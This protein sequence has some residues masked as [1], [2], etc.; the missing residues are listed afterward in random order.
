MSPFRHRPS[1]TAARRGWTVGVTLVAA[2]LS[3]PVVVVAAHVFV[4]AGDVW[5]HLV[6][7]V[8]D[9]YILNSLML[10]AGVTLGTLT[11][12][13]TTAWLASMC[14]FPGRSI[15]EW[16]SLLPMAL[17]AYIIAYTYTGLFDFAGPVQGALRSVA[18]WGYGDY[19]FPEIRSIWGA[20]AMLSLVLYPYVYLLTRAAF[21]SQS[22]CV[23]DAS[24]TLG[25]GPWRTFFTVALPL[26]RPATVAGLSLAL[27]ETLADYGTVQYF[28]V[29]TFTT[30][31]FRTWYGLDNAAAASQLAA[32]LLLFVVALIFLER[33]SRRHQRFH[34]TSQR[35]QDLDRIELKGARGII[36]FLLCLAPVLAGFVI[37]AAQLLVWTVEVWS[38]AVDAHFLTLVYNS[39]ELAVLASVLALFLA[40]LLGYGQRLNKSPWVNGAV[41]LAGM[42][43]AIPGTVIAI[44]VVIPLAWVDNTLDSFLRDTFNI[45]SGLLFSGTVFAL[46]FA[47]MVR[48]LAVS[49]QTVS[50]GLGRIKPSIDEAGRSLGHTPG[51]ILRA[52]HLPMLKGSL[53]TALLLVFVDVLKELPATLI[54]RPFNFNTLAVRA[55]EMASDERLAHAAPAALGIVVAGIVPVLLLSRSITRSRAVRAPAASTR[56]SP[57]LPAE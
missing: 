15:F 34:E 40:L 17:P 22:I 56:L 12:G 24:R 35:H 27:M 14:S 10:M 26:A 6:A 57:P 21:L 45:S 9:D 55:Y 51:S 33:Y 36:A 47:Y 28:G 38:E 53:W 25:N 43:Y 1:G 23:L 18:G 30:G 52:I 13:V 48:F 5:A 2:V 44:G 19:W 49:L 7:T 4:P 8:L 46:L 3:V 54:L 16:A 31:I 37:P 50:A 32:M 29:S 41:R 11:M 39:L 20:M 42:G